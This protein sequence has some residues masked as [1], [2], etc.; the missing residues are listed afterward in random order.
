MLKLLVASN[1][2]EYL[3]EVNKLYLEEDDII[4]IGWVNILSSDKYIG[5]ISSQELSKEEIQAILK[6]NGIRQKYGRLQKA[7]ESYRM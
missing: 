2:I 4:E 7:S 1:Y 6:K 5:I 3:N